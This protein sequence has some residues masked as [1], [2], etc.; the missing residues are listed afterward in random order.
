MDE[1]YEIQ[2][3][4]QVL[5]TVFLFNEICMFRLT[6]G[7]LLN[8]ILKPSMFKQ[9]YEQHPSLSP[10]MHIEEDPEVA[11]KTKLL[12]CVTVADRYANPRHIDF[13]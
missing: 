5:K 10:H 6:P 4:K 11:T 2:Q 3:K 12:T 9:Y 7:F 1:R 13:K 8:N